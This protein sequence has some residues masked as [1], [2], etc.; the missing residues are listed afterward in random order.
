MQTRWPRFLPGSGTLPLYLGTHNGPVSAGR[1]I[2]L[3]IAVISVIAI[4]VVTPK[5]RRAAR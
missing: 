3:I 2:E 4:A 5:K 1:M